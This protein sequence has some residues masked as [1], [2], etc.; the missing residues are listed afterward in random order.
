MTDNQKPVHFFDQEPEKAMNHQNPPRFLFLRLGLI[1]ALVI[2]PSLVA[3]TD[4]GEDE[5]ELVVLTPFEVTADK[6]R[7][8]ASLYTLGGSRI[9][10]SLNEVPTSVLVLN[11]E[12]LQDVVPLDV[13]DAVELD[14]SLQLAAGFRENTS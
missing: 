14:H 13:T 2:P 4:E 10:T 3:Q 12:F 7:G 1:L 11:Q 9:N 6:D 8:Y 5:E